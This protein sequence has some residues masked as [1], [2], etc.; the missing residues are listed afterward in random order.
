MRNIITKLTTSLIALTLSAGVLAQDTDTFHDVV[1]SKDA[2]NVFGLMAKN[3]KLPAWVMND[4]VDS[5]SHE[6]NINGTTWQVLEACKSHDC[7]SERVAV[8]WSSSTK[9]MAGVFSHVD[10]K[11]GGERLTWMNITDELSIDGKTALYSALTGSLDN[12]PGLF[13]FN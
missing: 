7:S 1:M 11:S 12:H 13:K 10:E 3:Y 2:K 8:L 4:S 6:V 9:Q 5:A